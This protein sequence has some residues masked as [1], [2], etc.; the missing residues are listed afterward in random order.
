M[1]ISFPRKIK[2]TFTENV[3]NTLFNYFPFY[4]KPS[5]LKNFNNNNTS[6][7]NSNS[8]K[9]YFTTSK[10]IEKK[11]FFKV[12]TPDI[13]NN[14]LNKKNKNNNLN[15][16]DKN[17][18]KDKDNISL[19]EKSEKN[20]KTEKKEKL[21]LFFKGKK[22]YIEIFN[23][24]ENAS[25][26]FLEIL[27]E[28]KIVQ[29]KRLCKNIDYIIFKEGHLKTK[30]YAVMNNIKMVNPLWVDDKINRNIF[31]DDKEY[32]VEINMGD[33]LLQEKL[34]KNKIDEKD[35][36]NE[37]EAEF[38]VEY[39]NMI[40]K[41]RE[42][43][44]K[45]SE[46]KNTKKHKNISNSISREKKKAKITKNKTE[47]IFLE[48]EPENKNKNKKLNQDINKNMIIE[49]FLETNHSSNNIINNEN[50]IENNNENNYNI[51]NVNNTDDF[52]IKENENINKKEVDN[53]KKNNP[54]II[55]KINKKEKINNYNNIIY[56][57]K[58]RSNFSIK[59]LGDNSKN[60]TNKSMQKAKSK[61]PDKIKSKKIRKSKMKSKGYKHVAT[62]KKIMV[63]NVTDMTLENYIS[64]DSNKDQS[65]I[66]SSLN[67][68]NQNINSNYSYTPNNKKM[69][70]NISDIISKEKSP[71]KSNIK[72]DITPKKSTLGQKIN[73]ITYKLEEK[74][75]QC[76][77][78]MHKFEYKGD[79]K[80]LSN[81][82]GTLYSSASVIILDKEKS[83]YDWKMYEFFFDKKILVDFANFLFEFMTEQINED[84]IDAQN[85]LEKLNKISI[86]EETYFFN[87]K[88][89]YQRRSLLHSYNIVENI[90]DHKKE[91]D[92]KSEKL[93]NFVLN[94]NII[95]GEK[96]IL[97]KILKFYLKANVI[98][99][100]L[101]AKRS[102]SMGPGFKF[103]LNTENI[104][105]SINEKRGKIFL[106]Q[107][108]CRYRDNEIDN[109][110]EKMDIIDEKEEEK[111]DKDFDETEEKQDKEE[112]QDDKEDKDKD[113]KE[114]KEDKED[115]E[116]I[117]DK[118]DKKDKEDKDNN[119]EKMKEE[120]ED[121]EDKEMKEEKE[122]K[123]NDDEK[124]TE[125]KEDK[126][127][128]EEEEK[129]EKDKDENSGNSNNSKKQEEE[130]EDDLTNEEKNELKDI[131]GDT[132]LI[133]KEKIVSKGFIKYIPNFKE[134]ISYK[135]AFDS[136]SAGELKNLNDEKILKKYLFE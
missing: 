19:N 21:I 72:K 24:K 123:D 20:E 110:N 41:Q 78:T 111:E 87:K 79:L 88:I 118:E 23:G 17:K 71:N 121:K 97:H 84:I 37:L 115:K 57:S 108:L 16:N 107:K 14:N 34:E 128:G 39:A 120:K 101:P 49:D 74:E 103:K 135:Y 131:E 26:V 58:S 68:E 109:D 9:T 92:E 4:T 8:T 43:E 105:A 11:N 75:I 82:Y 104:M 81:D 18:D 134:I 93:F 106:I 15:N 48:N 51:N 6:N 76:L 42:K 13:T 91:K 53:K 27:L 129:E 47:I 133:S 61:T 25:N 31:K 50:K 60:N 119:E 130:D 86:N 124:M 46:E 62:S 85:T 77:K 89:R 65:N 22:I 117:E 64:N 35:Y 125:E 112:K 126:E 1:S 52:I 59:N 44:L 63:T 36:E 94:K 136:F 69:A 122:D 28:Y 10:K 32:L 90:S 116:D 2:N 56:R 38:D 102:Q 70:K 5:N 100:E 33:I 95:G 114:M 113:E 99:V 3:E 7:S 83:K 98:K 73:I 96:R 12:I 80:N 30:K 40:D 66:D 132:Y 127:K 67:K 54:F 55:E 45:K 29:C